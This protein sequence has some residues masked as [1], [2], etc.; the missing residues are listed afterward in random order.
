ML[1]DFFLHLRAFRLPVSTRELLTLVEALDR[2]VVSSSIDDFYA[3]ARA[4]LV[5]D[6]QFYDRFD[7][8]FGSYFDGID[9]RFDAGAKVPDEWLRREL[10]RHLTDEDRRAIE[11]Q[12]GIERLLERFRERLAEQRERHQGG[13]RWIGA[14]GTSPFGAHGFHP[15]GIRLGPGSA[16]HRSAVRVRDPR[17]FRNLDGDVELNTRNLRIALRRLRRFAREGVADELDLDATVAGTARNAGWLDLRLRAERKNRVAVLLFLDVGGSMDPHVEICETLF[18]AARSEFR[19]L[20][21]FYF[22]NCIYDHVWRDNRRRR[23]ESVPTL[24]LLRTYGPDWKVVIVGDAAMSPYELTAIDGSAEY[25]NLE[26]GLTWLGRIFAHFRR[27]VWWNPEPERAW[28]ATR[29][30]ELIRG[31]LGPRMFPLTLDGIGA[32]IAALRH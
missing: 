25:R 32:G 14:G 3:V 20:E 12:G 24:G 7:A 11:A 2:R 4:C 15:E 30:T 10:V 28:P 8:A 1:V 23:S 17:E 27:V 21:T 26:P 5:K 13:S 18:S 6:E 19:R 29:S 22:H 31:A 16:G 9:R